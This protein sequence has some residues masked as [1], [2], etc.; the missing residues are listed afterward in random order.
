MAEHSSTDGSQSLN[1]SL[2]FS[3]FD[4][5]AF[6]SFSFVIFVPLILTFRNLDVSSYKLI[7]LVDETSLAFLFFRERDKFVLAPVLFLLE[8]SCDVFLSSSSELDDI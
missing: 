6:F 7:A 3:S 5:Y 8:V 2:A 1:F 4:R